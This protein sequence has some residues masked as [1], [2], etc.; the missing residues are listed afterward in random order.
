MKAVILVGG[1]HVGTRFRPLSLEVPKPL[2]PI[3]GSPMIQHIIEACTKLKEISEILLLGT[4]PVATMAKF[5][6]EMQAEYNITIRYLQEY[7]PLGTAGGLY[8]FRD[9][10]QRGNPS[11]FFVFNCDVC[12]EF[13]VVEMRK[14]HLETTKGEQFV[15]LGTEAN[16]TQALSYGCIAENPD[17]HEVR[18]YVEKPE[19]FISNVINAGVF[20]F[21][22][23]VFNLLAQVFESTMETATGT[24]LRHTDAMDLGTD[25]LRGLGGTGQLYVYKMKGFWSQVKNAGS[26]LYANN[27]YLSQYRTL[28]PA[29]L[30]HNTQGGPRII[31]DVRI[32]PSAQIHPS[33]V[34]GPNVYVGMN[35]VIRSGARVREAIILDRAEIKDHSCILHSII[36][37]DCILGAWSRIEG[38][39]SN[40]NPNDPLAH[41]STESLFNDDGRLN[42][43]ITVIGEGVIVH[44]ELMVLNSIVLP[45]KDLTANF[46]NQII[47]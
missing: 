25:L 8:H 17:T 28:N 22:S 15:I 43:S 16:E 38:Y 34:L 31:G 45:H 3:A 39:P 46:K 10:I 35:V 1:P 24:R 2:F 19:T 30:A 42:P 18:H 20:L 13:P 21:T 9:Q 14:F 37:W 47:L 23:K 11:A 44:P 36:G 33:A 32:H 4:Y 12:C 5:V 7:T 40:L 41:L 27:L 29:L 26:A 6:K